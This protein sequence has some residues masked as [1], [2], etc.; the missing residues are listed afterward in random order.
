M[1]LLF[2]NRQYQVPSPLWPLDG[3][4]ERPR[5]VIHV[6]VIGPAATE[7]KEGLL[8]TGSD[9][10]VFPDHMAA[11]LGI[12]L[13]NAPRG[14]AR[15]VGGPG[16]AVRYAEVQLRITDGREFREWK[17]KVGFTSTPLNRPLLGF[18]G[19]LQFFT[20]TFHGDR[21][22]VELTVNSRYRGT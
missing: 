2:R 19:F 4:S 22:E 20:A 6:T 18:S 8:D 5:P 12:D 14:T 11:S 16:R 13:T 15:G 3:R 7:L 17:A 21:E 9:D 1:S 10:T